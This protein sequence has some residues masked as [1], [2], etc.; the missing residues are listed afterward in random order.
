MTEEHAVRVIV[1]RADAPRTSTTVGSYFD[2]VGSRLVLPPGSSFNIYAMNAVFP[3]VALRAG[4]LPDDDWLA[5]KPW[6]CSPDPRENVVMRLDRIA[7]STDPVL[8]AQLDALPAPLNT[9]STETASSEAG[10]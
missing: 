1:D 10:R 8:A 2:I 6:I 5:R 4:E 7:V 9:A 3:V